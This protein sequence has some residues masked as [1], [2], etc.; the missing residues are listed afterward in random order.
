MGLKSELTQEE[1]AQIDILR[2]ANPDWSG[3][4]IGQEIRR[5]KS[6]VNRYLKDPENYGRTPR[7]GRPR[8]IP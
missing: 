3:G 5:S 2:Q 4:R 6:T 1:R 8:V 7:K